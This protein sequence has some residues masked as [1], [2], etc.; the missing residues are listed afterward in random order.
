MQRAQHLWFSVVAGFLVHQLQH[1]TTRLMKIQTEQTES[2]LIAN[3][4]GRIDSGN[5][6]EFNERLTAVIEDQDQALILDCEGLEYISSAGLRVILMVAKTLQSQNRQF[7]ICSL[8]ASIR[9][10][11]SISGFDRIIPI[12]D[13]QAKALA[14]MD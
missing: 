5:A 6:K 13:T 8:T 10:L 7:T 11:F 2:A 4:E 12:H 9:E 14:S 3:L 1:G